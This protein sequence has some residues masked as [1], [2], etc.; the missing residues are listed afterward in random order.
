MLPNTKK[1]NPTALLRT[2]TEV[3]Y[4]MIKLLL[5][6]SVAFVEPQHLFSKQYATALQETAGKWSK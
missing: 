3:G 6:Q 2:A 5:Y 4:G 1:E